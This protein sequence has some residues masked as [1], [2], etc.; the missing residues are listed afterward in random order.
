[1]VAVAAVV[2]KGPTPAQP[3]GLYASADSIAGNER[4]GI[5]G[6]HRVTVH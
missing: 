2:R 6:C 4:T 1:M 5:G 3:A